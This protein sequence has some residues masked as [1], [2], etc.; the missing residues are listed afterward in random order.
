MLHLVKTAQGGG[1]DILV[2]ATAAP[3]DDE[4]LRLAAVMRYEIL[5]TAPDAVCDRITALAAD[6][7][8]VPISIIGFV[9]RDRIWFKSHHGLDATE[10]ERY[11]ARGAVV[12]PSIGYTLPSGRKTDIWSTDIRSTD[13]R[14]TELRS[15]ATPHVV[16]EAGRR[17]CIAVPLQ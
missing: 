6:L 9:D 7:F 17:F 2:S 1:L 5:D 12:L 16:G 10:I 8:N 15:I 14:S 13:L 3:S 11:A 4:R